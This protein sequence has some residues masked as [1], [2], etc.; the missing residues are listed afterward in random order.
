MVSNLNFL[1]SFHTKDLW[2]TSPI[3]END[4]IQKQRSSAPS[5]FL[6]MASVTFARPPIAV[7]TNRMTGFAVGM[8]NVFPVLEKSIRKIFVVTVY[9]MQLLAVGK[10]EDVYV[11]SWFMFIVVMAFPAGNF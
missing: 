10:G 2:I 3:F 1:I 11:S 5:F 4:H 6:D 7:Y 8:E 9:A